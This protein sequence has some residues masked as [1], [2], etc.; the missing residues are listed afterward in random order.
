[1]Y[2]LFYNFFVCSEI[3][4]NEVLLKDY[5]LYKKFLDSLT[6]SEWKEENRKERLEKRNQKNKE[7]GK[8]SSAS[9]KKGRHIVENMD[10]VK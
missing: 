6:P 9:R 5:Q 3:S 1:M 8:L 7:R 4:K 2:I 10:A